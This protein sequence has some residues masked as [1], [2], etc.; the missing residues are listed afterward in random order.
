MIS[1]FFIEKLEGVCITLDCAQV[2]ISLCLLFKTN[3]FKF[4]YNI[5]AK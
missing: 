5:F 2:T 3:P 4:E 1:N